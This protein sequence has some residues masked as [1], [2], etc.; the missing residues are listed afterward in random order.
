MSDGAT[1]AVETGGPADKAGISEKDIITKIN[2]ASVGEAG[3]V[4]TLIGAYAPGETVTVTYLR[5]GS[6]RTTKVT[7]ATYRAN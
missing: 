6:E 7:L 2:G 4:S 5:G 1:S 3:G